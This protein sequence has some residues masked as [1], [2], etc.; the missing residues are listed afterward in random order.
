[1]AT[2]TH[3]EAGERTFGIS[4]GQGSLWVT[5]RGEYQD[6]MEAAVNALT[7]Y[8]ERRASEDGLK[9]NCSRHES[10]PETANHPE[11]AEHVRGACRSLNIPVS[12]MQAPFRASEDFG[13]FLNRVPGAMFLVG[14]GDIPAVH[15]TGYDFPDGIIERSIKLLRRLGEIA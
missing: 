12:E 2:L 8:A 15:T 5:C 11:M 10:F 4:A 9:L 1:M 3:A 13:H 6:E 14:G 7:G